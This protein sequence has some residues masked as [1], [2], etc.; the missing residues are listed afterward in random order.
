MKYN[1]LNEKRIVEQ[2][3][4]EW[5]NKNNTTYGS[6]FHGKNIT[7]LLLKEKENINSIADIGTGRGEF[8]KWAS[9]NL[10]KEVYGVDFAF[11]PYEYNKDK[12]ITYYKAFA[13]EL[14]L[15]DKQVDVLTSFDMLEHLV[16]GDV[17]NVFEEFYRITKK[18]FIFSICTRDS[19]GFRDQ[20][21]TLHPTVKEL[22]WWH[23]KISKYGEIKCY[24][25]YTI[26]NLK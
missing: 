3:K 6:S 25:E 12:H 13:H 9:L 4:Y 17:E 1:T 5:I 18:L 7:K 16:E 21:G 20:L 2:K 11:D 26:V 14:P 22:D 15:K 23:N 19:T 24:N 10:C 8:C